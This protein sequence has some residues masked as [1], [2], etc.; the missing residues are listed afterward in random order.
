[1]YGLMKT[2]LTRLLFM[3]V[4]AL[5]ASPAFAAPPV[6]SG[7]D[8]L[9]ITF[10]EDDSGNFSV[11]SLFED[12]VFANAPIFFSIGALSPS[13]ILTVTGTGPRDSV[14]AYTGLQDAFGVATATLSAS[15][16]LG[17][18]TTVTVQFEVTAV[19]DDP[20]VIL[21][22]SDLSGPE[23][24]TGAPAIDLVDHFADVDNETLTFTIASQSDSGALDVS[25]NG[26]SLD[27][28]PIPNAF[29]TNFITI[30]AE[31][32][33][34]RQECDD[35]VIEITPVDDPTT[36]ISNLGSLTID[37]DEPS[38][39]AI[40]LTAIFEDVDSVLTYT[41]AVTPSG[42]ISA[43]VVGDQL[44]LSTN[45]HVFG[46]GT[47]E[48]VATG[49]DAPV[50]STLSLTITSVPDAPEVV[51]PLGNLDILEDQASIPDL[52]LDNHFTD[53]DGEALTYT[54][55][56]SPATVVT[57]TQS[58]SL[59][60]FNSILNENGQA[61]VVVTADNAA[62]P[63]ISDTL[64]INVQ[65]VDDP[66]VR[67]ALPPVITF[68]E[69]QS[70][71]LP[72][73]DLDTLYSD[74]DTP[75]LIYTLV[76]NLP[77]GRVGASISGSVLSFS[78]VADENGT[79]TIQISASDGSATATEDST[80]TVQIAPVNDAPVNDVP[81]ADVS[82]S[83]DATS[84]PTVSLLD[85]FDDVDGDLLSYS[86][87]SVS[88]TGII[89][90][91]VSGSVVQFSTF[92]DQVGTVSVV[93]EAIDGGTVGVQD[94]F[95]VEVTPL[96]DAPRVDAPVPPQVI[97]EDSS[98][99]SFDLN[100]VF[101]D[102]D[103]DN[104]TY[105]VTSNSEA[106]VVDA[107]VT[108]NTVSI[109]PLL[110]QSAPL[111]TIGIEAE[112]PTG[113]IEVTQIEL[114]VN[115]VNDLPTII[116]PTPV[117][118]TEDTA[119]TLTADS[120]QWFDDV[121][122]PFGDVLTYT[123]SGI[124]GAPVFVPGSVNVDPAGLVSF[125]LALNE[126]GIGFI[127]VTAT[128]QSGSDATVVFQVTVNAVNDPPVVD[129]PLPV[130]VRFED[131][132]PAPE[133]S[134]AGVFRDDDIGFTGDVLTY[135]ASPLAGLGDFTV[136]GEILTFN[137]ILHANGSGTVTVTAT[138]QAGESAITTFELQI[139]PTNDAPFPNAVQPALVQIPED[140]ATTPI[141]LLPYFDDVDLT[142][143]G[144]TLTFEITS[145]GTSP[146]FNSIAVVGGNLEV[147]PALNAV[148]TH[149]VMVRA[150]DQGGLAS[151]PVP[152]DLEVLLVIAIAFDD[153]ASTDEGIPLDQP[154]SGDPLNPAPFEAID[155]LA[156]DIEGDPAT[157]IISAG[158]DLDLGAE[159]IFPNATQSPPT[160][161][162][163]SLGIGQLSPNG[164]VEIVGNRIHYFPKE[165]FNGTDFFDYTIQDGDGDVSTA[166]VT[167]TVANVNTPP[168]API[169]PTFDIFQG[170]TLNVI[171]E[172]GLVD[173]GF[174]ADGDD[175]TVTYDNIPDALIAPTF[176]RSP[177]GSFMLTPD[178]AFVGQI[179]FTIR[180]N[181]AGPIASNEVTVT[182]NVAP[183]P[184]PPAAPP[185]GEVEFDMN[186]ADVPLE[187]AIS[188][189]ANVLVVMDDSG[190]MDWDM[191]TNQ[192]SG[193]FRLDN[194]T[195]GRAP[196][197]SGRGTW[198]Y[199]IYAL[200]TNIFNL[201][202]APTQETVDARSGAGQ[203]LEHNQ[204]GVWRLRNSQYSTIYYNPEIEYL[205]WRGLDRNN[206][207]FQD[208]P[209]TAAPLDPFSNNNQ[210]LN[211]TLNYNFNSSNV[212][213]FNNVSSG[214]RTYTNT[215]VYFPYY[216]T[217]TVA[218]R[219]EWDDPRTRITIDDPTATYP[220]GISRLDCA[221]TDGNPLTCSY[222]EE[223]QNFA[224][225]FTYYRSREFTAKAA[226]GRALA[227]TANLRMGYAVLNDSN[228]RVAIRSLN[229]SF[230]TGHKADLLEQ[231]YETSSGGGTPLRRALDRAGRHFE[232][233][234][235]DSFGSTGTTTPGSPA[236]PILP[237]PE[238]QCQNNFTLLFS[239]GTWNG[240]NTGTT[241]TD[242]NNATGTAVNTV[243]DG[244]VFGDNI[245][246]TLADIAM[247]Y[248]ERDLHPGIPDGVPTNA[249]DTNLAPPGSFLEDDELM[250]QHMK[251]YTVGFGV[252]G[253]VELSDL[254]NNG[255]NPDTG[256]PVID[257]TQPFSWPNPFASNQA[258]TDD[259]LH[260]AL[261]GRG[262]FLQA[263]NPV[264]LGQAFRDAFEEFSDGS[265]SVSAVAF[266]ST[267]LREGTVE[268]RGFFNLRF[269][270]GD[271]EALELLDPI[272][273][274]PPAA[275]LVWSAADQMQGVDPNTRNIFTYDRQA[276]N[277][278]P[279]RFNALNSDQ[280][281]ILSLLEVDYLRGD[282]SREEPAGPFRTRNSVLGDIVNSAP[283]S[284]GAPQGIRRDR[285]P[286]PTDVLYSDFRQAY[287][288]RRRV[289]YVGAN[290]G[291]LHA[292][293][294]GFEDRTPID[295]GTGN[296]LFA[297]IPNKLIDSSQRFNNDLDQLSSLVYSHR[298]FV[299]LTPTVDDAFIRPNGTGVQAW[300]TLMVGG[301]RGGGKGYFALDI[302][303]P[304]TMAVSEING[305]N[306]VL[307]EFTDAD[308]T[309]P[310]ED[311]G[312]PLGGSFGAIT[313]LAGEPVKDLGYS[314]TEPRIIMT[315]VDGASANR[316]KWAAV[317][318]NGYN[319]TAGIAKLFVLFIDD[320]VN[321][322]QN[323]DFIKIN[324]GAGTIATNP[325]DPANQDPTAGIPNGLGQP[326]IIDTDLDG[327]GD[328]AYAGDL[329]GNLY[330]FEIGDPNPANWQAVLLFTATLDGTTQTRQPITT[331]PVVTKVPDQEGFIVTFGTG[332]FI[333]E[334]DGL[335]TDVQSIY[336]IWDRFEI[337]PRTAINNAKGTLL[338]EQEITNIVDDTNGLDTLRIMSRN[339]V[340]LIPGTAA[341]ANYGWFID[342]D[343]VRASTS[344]QGN[345]NT[346]TGG[347][348]PPNPQYPG[349]RA[350]R[351]IV[352]R[353]SAL[354]ITTVIPRDANSCFR[355]PPGAIWFID[356][357]S[358]GDPGRPI[359]D[360]DNDGLIDQNDLITV[361]G[362]EFAAGIL[363]DAGSGDGSLVDPSV[364]LGDGDTDFLV[365]N[366][367]HGEDPQIIR[368]IKDGNRKTGRLSWWE[369]LGE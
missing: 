50:S 209:P 275:P 140:A 178:P 22:L 125:T 319:S 272:T 159:G 92:P 302:T 111:V 282:Q 349:E 57:V 28:A 128:D 206:N 215:S 332:S 133:I 183:T 60:S 320:G 13:D 105:R 88:P 348:A 274:L 342:L 309:Y 280:T 306:S 82:I 38:I 166:R 155:V 220:G 318:G 89:D 281:G 352:R 230:R 325:S 95:Q 26:T 152:V 237:L 346:D 300:R 311:N 201:P 167:I 145:A 315:N 181:D 287:E 197:V 148:G 301:L 29:G 132:T 6:Y 329:Q 361:G 297:F 67:V 338:V 283:V 260:A 292:F 235:G 123:E 261:N 102:P 190:S 252:V 172:G 68:D 110:N 240:S 20:D 331:A 328:T 202:V 104:L 5:G 119:G 258:K 169:S 291:M 176:N 185:A 247:H 112:D 31:D 142:R 163:T 70:G 56:V 351:Q 139:D 267:R 151:S 251:T 86:V 37:E 317:F 357:L 249:R 168:E 27:L 234:A 232:C 43:S 205:P 290:D 19:P 76:S 24:F 127:S 91:T 366:K 174:D 15:N 1:M 143:E 369:I 259:M 94:S 103:G 153:V 90:A 53:G 217:T 130:Q 211:L 345:P 177:D 242:S 250:H 308:D 324:T 124:T 137:Q 194:A 305:A 161:T 100:T 343:P 189:E 224:N 3:A 221:E 288:N 162:L 54:F 266:G 65:P 279:F 2:S 115:P 12:P 165:G 286:F 117:E 45:A 359:I 16:L 213:V 135:T 33:T 188:T 236:C 298:F 62:G 322:W 121:D 356:A 80:V 72:T 268:Y 336:G 269:N 193:V 199:Y 316:K 264:L 101:I 313:D 364:L 262:Q 144:D 106:T 363:F 303:D 263:N 223:L 226:L 368:I 256:L 365:I 289:V 173:L 285:A 225:W 79:A 114:Q 120:T 327:I 216:Y 350:I 4:F 77:S 284:V 46:S 55:T 84:P 30:C 154:A 182:V 73:L 212:P 192:S 87:V 353:G 66:P 138:D 227:D 358:G 360:T 294:A 265:V 179:T 122:L 75:S 295:N 330:R 175:L 228:D 354:V 96:P 8:P 36:L 164:R 196:G 334:E 7:S 156:N 32:P 229:S 9:V 116:N 21:P 58:G 71:S 278:I 355:A 126:S 146:L 195:G 271:L 219:P 129:N 99:I 248:Y 307:W 25:I 273:G 39:P 246:D 299:D 257:F 310:V 244:G 312:V 149:T 49:D 238:G 186:L 93:V 34:G 118:F 184:P 362:E 293:D 40:D 150:I 340:N 64:T 204:F 296:E 314:Y 98:P 344:L 11:D 157:V 339:V 170:D 85:A 42:L 341:D 17:E 203:D 61:T 44:Q 63:A 134:L 333:T 218:G 277:G 14:L 147:E 10:D 243:F 222:T 335:S 200:P 48:V 69:D 141:A 83:E 113:L 245:N 241:N 323:G 210:T 51:Q 78:P 367:S 74:P 347:L 214:R 109:V 231:V 254:P 52:N 160:E 107:S 304:D 136:S 18:T 253:G 208:A 191:M 239:D 59:L 35:M 47:V 321:G 276:L 23:D 187:D 171:A 131:A 255:I 198:Y 158:V 180:Y 108:G 270:T 207:D 97:D 326:T 337:A 41:I 81:L 233:R